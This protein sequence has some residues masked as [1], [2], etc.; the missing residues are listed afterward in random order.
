M[1]LRVIFNLAILV[2][3]ILVTESSAFSTVKET[4][5]S[6]RESNSVTSNFLNWNVT[7][8]E[9]N[10]T[11]GENATFTIENCSYILNGSIKLRDQGTLIIRNATLNITQNHPGHHEI[12]IDNAKMTCEKAN[13][14]SNHDLK[15]SSYKQSEITIID[16]EIKASLPSKIRNEFTG[17]S[18]VTIINSILDEVQGGD[19]AKISITEST[20]LQITAC[21]PTK[22]LMSV[23]N[24]TIDKIIADF[25]SE[26]WITR[27]EV[28]TVSCMGNATVRLL[29]SNISTT[30]QVLENG[31]FHRIWSLMTTVTL[32]AFILQGVKVECL[33]SFNKT[34][35]AFG[36]T[37]TGGRA[38][39]MLTEKIINA[40]TTLDVGKYVVRVSHRNLSDEI[41]VEL[42]SDK[43]ITI[44]L[45][46]DVAPKIDQVTYDPNSPTDEENVT[47]TSRVIDDETGIASVLVKYTSDGGD[48]WKT[49][50][51]EQRVNNT[52]LAT[53]PRQDEGTIVEFYIVAFDEVA[54]RGETD[55]YSYSVPSFGLWWQ[56]SWFMLVPVLIVVGIIVL[57]VNL[58]RRARIQAKR[59]KYIL[60][61]EK[62]YHA[63][64]Q[65]L[66]ALQYFYTIPDKNI[67][68]NRQKPLKTSLNRL[69]IGANSIVL[70]QCL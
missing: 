22:P 69:G 55:Y 27:S 12:I 67:H 53:V 48:T 52:Y 35:V 57:F 32:N 38:E 40:T 61:K 49:I 28:N 30:P 5:E 42:K 10:I 29:S 31:T 18:N 26:M 65:R 11:V 17:T 58:R 15:L 33:F 14:T 46:D 7:T 60:G 37:Q 1:K 3:S 68:S 66:H 23:T 6:N 2:I 13:I 16:S 4:H 45:I 50:L 20:M 34:I 41:D 51:M 56:E 8:Y 70:Y 44:A 21:C 63:C 64:G 19:L 39:F 24:S 25:N 62:M 59:E 54:N 43:E 9:G 47:V 36:E